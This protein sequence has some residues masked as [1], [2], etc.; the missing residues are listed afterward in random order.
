M[1]KLTW[2]VLSVAAAAM[3]IAIGSTA[4]VRAEERVV[5]AKVPFAFH[6]GNVRLPAGDYVVKAVSFGSNVLLIQGADG[7][8]TLA[9]STSSSGF[10]RAAQPELVFEKV[11]TQ[12]FL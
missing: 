12:Y 1:K 7:Q 6:V 2:S 8:S 11:G 10:N 3:S 5:T 4:P 9:Q